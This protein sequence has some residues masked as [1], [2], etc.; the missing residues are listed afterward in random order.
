MNLAKA[1]VVGRPATH[2]L[3]FSQVEDLSRKLASVHP[4][5]RRDVDTASRL[6]FMP[7]HRRRLSLRINAERHTVRLAGWITQVNL[8][9][10]WLTIQTRRDN[11]IH[12]GRASV[13]CV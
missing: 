8:V 3:G 13:C 4:N 7:Y 12:A 6:L 2:Y 1:E 11:R 9:L 5:K 10:A